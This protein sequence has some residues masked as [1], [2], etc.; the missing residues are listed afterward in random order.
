VRLARAAATTALLLAAGCGTGHRAG[1]ALPDLRPEVRLTA[2][3][4][5]GSETNYRVDLS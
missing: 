1:T 3:P 5:A 4:R 2:A